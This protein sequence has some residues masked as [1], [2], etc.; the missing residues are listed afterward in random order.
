[1]IY[2]VATATDVAELA[3]MRWDFRL[4]EAQG[5]P[6][7]DRDTFLHACAAFLRQG[8]ADQRWTYWIATTDAEIVSHIF[9]QHISKVPKPNRL[10]EA[11]GYVTNVYTRPTYRN[12][13]I[14]TKL[15]AHVL[16]WATEQDLESLIVWPSTAS[17]RF[18]ERAGFHQ[19][20]E[21]LEYE[22]RPYIL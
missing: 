20:S 15:M 19:G 10:A 21:M 3:S 11:L 8:L 6:V 4:E 18:Y 12:R 13:G 5:T 22:V 7:H 16:Q 2:R 14:G 1:M 17:I 9:I